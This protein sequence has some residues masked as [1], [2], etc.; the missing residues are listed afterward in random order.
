MTF[1]RGNGQVQAP[2]FGF[3]VQSL[4]GRIALSRLCQAGVL[5]LAISGAL[6][7][8]P[9]WAD[10]SPQVADGVTATCTGTTLNQ[11]GGAPG[12][13]GGTAG[14]GTGAETGVTVNVDSGAANTVT[15]TNN[16]INLGDAT[17]INKAG[18]TIAGGRPEFTVSV[19][20]PTS[21]IPAPSPAPAASALSA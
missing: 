7:A 3:S 18:G 10:C 13:S 21:P 17:V 19:A 4:L 8:T 6:I 12:T 16:G 2:R 14:Y 1:G 11:G 20:S 9:A 5:G 15:G